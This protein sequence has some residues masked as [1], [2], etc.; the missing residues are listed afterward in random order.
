MPSPLSAESLSR[1]RFLALVGTVPLVGLIPNFLRGAEPRS[2]DAGD[3]ETSKRIIPI[4]LELYSVRTELARDLPG[5]LTQVAKIGYQYVEFYAPYFEWT[6]AYARDVR[7][8]MDDLGLR[9]HSTHN[10][11]ESFG[12]GPSGLSKAIDLNQILGAKQ[13]ILATAPRGTDSGEAWRRLANELTVAVGELQKVGL[14]AGFH[15]H[16]T[17]WKPIEGELRAMDILAQHTPREFVLQLDVGTCIEAGVDPVAWI[18]ANPGRIRSV[19]LKDWAPGS[20][21]ED[22]GY[23]VLFG[24]GVA[25]WSQIISAATEVGGVELFLMEQEGSRYSEFE[26]AERCLANWRGVTRTI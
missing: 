11:F 2:T 12:T 4:G 10:H 15:N 20:E 7:A 9:C 24:E 14:T 19:H 5:T 16:Q 23:R 25:P 17:E 18:R 1:R 26:T 13:L 6:A 8:R 3:R 22:K 21:K